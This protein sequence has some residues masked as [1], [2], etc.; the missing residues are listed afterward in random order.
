MPILKNNPTLSDLQA[1]VTEL[2]QERGFDKNTVTQK[3]I[4][5]GEE[6]GELFKAIRKSHAGMR[7]DT[8]DYEARPA[9]ELADMLVLICAIANRLDISL[10][11]ASRDK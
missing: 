2:E 1:Y 9:E 7:L 6:L 4:L 10:E 8:K 11:H 3:C 5:L